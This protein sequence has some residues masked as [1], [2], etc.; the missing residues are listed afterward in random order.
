MM[1]VSLKSNGAP[2]A[3]CASAHEK[4]ARLDSTRFAAIRRH[5]PAWKFSDSWSSSPS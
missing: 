3:G 2:S 1:S 5:A 4:T